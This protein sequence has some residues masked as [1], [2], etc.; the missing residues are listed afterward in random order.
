LARPN[1]IQLGRYVKPGG[2]VMPTA[3]ESSTWV[4]RATCNKTKSRLGPETVNHSPEGSCHR[5]SAVGDE[6]ALINC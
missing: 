2:G 4:L 6:L 5:T 1:L 3:P